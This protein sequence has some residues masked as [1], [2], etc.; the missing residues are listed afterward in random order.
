M[1]LYMFVMF[2]VCF[3]VPQ[4][5]LSMCLYMFAMFH[6]CFLVM[7]VCPTVLFVYVF[8]NVRYVI[9]SFLVIIFAMFFDWGRGSLPRRVWRA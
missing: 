7:L 1:C 3:L 2:H 5:F 9:C 4:S 6:V 8:V